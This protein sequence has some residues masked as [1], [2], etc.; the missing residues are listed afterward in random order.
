[1]IRLYLAVSVEPSNYFIRSV[2]KEA[3]NT[4]YFRHIRPS[5]S[6]ST[7]VSAYRPLEGFSWNFT[8]EIFTKICR[9]TTH[10]ARQYTQN[11]TVLPWQGF[12]ILITSFTA[13][14]V[15]QHQNGNTLLRCHVNYGFKSASQ[16]YVLCTL[17]IPFMIMSNGSFIQYTVYDLQTI[18]SRKPYDVKRKGIYCKRFKNCA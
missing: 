5:V 1:M 7:R 8:L 3:K 6:M 17:P 16:G 14:Y 18:I 15:R 4:Y 11:E 9:E 13:T 12:V 2:R 10:L